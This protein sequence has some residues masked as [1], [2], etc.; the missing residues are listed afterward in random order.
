MQAI[1]LAAGM[2]RRLGALTKDNTKC[3]IE[4]NGVKLIDRLL[5]QLSKLS[6]TRVV[7]VVGYKGQELIDYLGQ[8]YDDKIK[9]EFIENPVYAS[10]NNIYSLALAKDQLQQDDTL[11]IESDLI[12]EDRMFDLVLNDKD[13]N[14]AL[15]AKYET[16]MDGT[17][18]RIDEDYNIVN[19]VPKKAFKYADKDSYYKTCNIYKFSKEFAAQKYVPFLEVYMKALGCNEYYEQVLRVIT[20]LDKSEVKALPITDEKWYEIDDIQDLDIAQTIFSSG[21]DLWKNYSKRFGGFWRFPQM[22]DFNYLVNPFFPSERMIDELEA[23][24]KPLLTE[25]PSGMYVNSLLAGKYF[26]VRQEYIVPGNGAAELIKSAMESLEGKLGVIY[27]TFEEYPNR[28]SADLVIYHPNNSDLH[29][30]AEDLKAFFEKN[31]VKNLLLINPDNPSGNYLSP[32]EVKGLAKWAADRHIRLIVDESFVDF[33]QDY[34][35]NT[36]ITNDILEQFPT[37]LVMKSISKSFGVPGLRLGVL[38]SADQ[39][40]IN[41]IKKDVSIWNINSFA[42]FYMQIFGKYESDYQRACEKFQGERKRFS[43]ELSRI[44]YLRVIPS[45]ANYF[46]CE[47]IG[48]CTA[49]SLAITLIK[50]DNILIKDC[51]Y[52]KAFEGKQYVRI[53]VRGK[54]DND[55]L[56]EALQAIASK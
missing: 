7:I 14:V 47:V 19:F 25:Y 24:F 42:E 38:A 32:E 44:P 30:T 49:T 46:L 50:R 20:F 27:P 16:W 10:T 23:N 8:R 4:V 29:Y 1:I 35:H 9:L 22:L 54:E 48:T 17:M 11:L 36:L 41:H 18:V 5:G 53:A 52:K 2:G 56:I 15:V 43:A 6:L 21:E 51:S 40:L 34:G 55:K 39:D 28:K 37:M 13:P 12:F 33:A 45:Q 3:M 31:P 26:G